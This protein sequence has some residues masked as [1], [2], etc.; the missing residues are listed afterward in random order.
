MAH[1][2]R[3]MKC[4]AAAIAVLTL[5]MA[6][7]GCEGGSPGRS[8]SGSGQGPSFTD[9]VTNLASISDSTGRAREAL[10]VAETLRAYH[11]GYTVDS[12][13]FIWFYGD[14]REVFAAGDFNGWNPSETP[15]LRVPHTGFFW[16]ALSFDPS[17]RVEYKL[18][19]DG[20]WTLDPANPDTSMGG[21]GPNS[22]LRMPGY[23]EPSEIIP[24]PAVPKGSLD[25]LVFQSVT[26]GRPFWV[27][28]YIPAGVPGGSRRLPSITVGDGG[29]YLRFAR[30]RTVLD[31]LIGR[32]HLPPLIG[33]FLEPRTDPLND[34]T[35]TRM[36][37]YTLNS[38][39]VDFLAGELRDTLLHRYPVSDDPR[40]TA[41]LGA[42]LGGLLAT[43][44]AL[45]HPEV[46]GLCAA[47][48]P[49]YQIM[50][51][52]I[53]SIAGASHAAPGKMYLDTGTLGD[54]QRQAA[55]MRAV[56]A[57]LGWR[58]RYIEV[59][60]GHNWA[61]WRARLDELLLFLFGSE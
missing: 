12:T 24:W 15:L 34:R 16:T 36:S 48:S 30:I 29:D 35:N 39:F 47:Q 25:S 19:V 5:M 45:L 41:I 2:L 61:S 7:V 43:H 51:D 50:N 20:Q 54:A 38:R 55:K 57:T 58:L 8:S 56:L 31:N 44:T 9:L 4:P 21:F 52:S 3:K 32:G 33:F 37:E 13:A 14:A 26:L 22:E 40:Q 17:A 27:Y 42:S 49:A 18:V 60:E 1:L 10:A 46:Y 59:P 6:L 23:Q 11:R 53:F 28:V